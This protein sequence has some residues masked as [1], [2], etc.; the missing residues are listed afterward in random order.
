[1]PD[2][3]NAVPMLAPDGSIRQVPQ[4]QTSAAVQ[5]GGKLVTQMVSPQGDKRWVPFDSVH[6][7][8][9]SGGQLAPPALTVGAP[10][11]QPIQTMD[12]RLQLPGQPG[13]TGAPPSV[14][15][16]APNE[17]TPE[18]SA[19]A[20][21]QREAQNPI[22]STVGHV[23][24]GAGKGLGQTLAPGPRTAAA[25]NKTTGL[26]VPS[27]NDPSLQTQ[28]TAEGVGAGAEGILEFMAGD[29]ALKGL[30]LAEK[31]G[32]GAK[33]AK[34]AEDSPFAAKII[35]TGLNSL[36]VGA[37]QG[38]AHGQSI[39]DA[40]K[41]GAVAGLAGGALETGAE[42]IK[43]LAPA[44]KE[45]AGEEIPVRG[46]QD[47]GVARAA[48]NAAPSKTLEKFDT[49]QTQPAAKRAIGNIATEVKNAAAEKLPARDAEAAIQKLRDATKTAENLGDAA[50]V[51]RD[52][53][54]PV[55]EKLDALTK[56]Q[57]MTFS[58]YQQ[59]ERG[60][61]RRGDIQAAKEARAA[62]ENILTQYQNQFNP[63]DLQA[64]RTN[65]RQASALDDV[66][67]SLNSKSVVG[68][69]P[70]KLRPVGSPDPGVING[71]NFS[72]EILKLA[73]DGTLQ[74][75]GLTPDHVQSLQ[76][77][78]TLLEKSAVD[79]PDS[80]NKAFKVAKV[81]V[82]GPAT[83]GTGY[84]ASLGLGKIMTDPAAAAKVLKAVQGTAKVAPSVA[85]QATRN[86]L[87]GAKPALAGD[88]R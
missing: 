35:R 48:E 69:T 38:L 6:D 68:P 76:D 67:D 1:M 37:A 5:A 84:L 58:D 28:G 87:D 71:K 2:N 70:V 18:G 61:F 40:A 25:I 83:G 19:A 22:I 13:G 53:S 78:G 55:F 32:I 14:Y 11:N 59:Q 74:R 10:Q 73:N 82:G 77:I 9:K 26:A 31:L 64:A 85:A 63:D 49:E 79:K 75:A 16:A 42:G 7:A 54:K 56:G 80:L 66:H 20:I 15:Q 57:E 44:V 24:I 36:T 65:W 86:I 27:F 88:N 39:G 43:A 50:Q 33:I 8:I 72:K 46:S 34:L 51:V 45:I 81:A 23:A 30:S 3:S 21:A 52:Q 12:Q 41:T 17:S 4:E 47:S 29:E 60:A 62:Q